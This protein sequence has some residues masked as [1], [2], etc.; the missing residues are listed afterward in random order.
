MGMARIPWWTT[1][2][3]GFYGGLTKD[4]EFQELLVRWFQFGAFCPVMRLHG[5]REPTRIP[6]L[7]EGGASESPTRA[8]NELWSF[9][10]YN[11][12]IL[13]KFVKMRYRIRGY[14]RDL[15]KEASAQG[16]PLMRSLFFEFPDDSRCWENETQYIFGNKYLCAPVLASGV[17]VQTVYLPKGASWAR[18]VVGENPDHLEGELEGRQDIIV[19]APIHDMPVF[20]RLL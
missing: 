9:G 18:F 7:Q 19:S 20:Y 3:G 13:R 8:E 12:P 6:S 15:M 1:D 16:S 14:V 2:I 5:C 11:Y 4:P 17:Q 10:D